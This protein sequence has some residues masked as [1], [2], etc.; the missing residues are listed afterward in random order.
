M[1][2]IGKDSG[3]TQ[4]TEDA[5]ICIFFAHGECHR[6]EKCYYKH[7]IPTEGDELRL[8]LL[9]DVFGRDRHKTDREDMG[10]IGSFSRNNRTLY[11]GG[12]SIKERTQN[13]LEGVL[14]R[15]F[16]P[17]GEIE[18]IRVI[19][20][21]SIGFVRYKLRAAAEF[22]KEAMHDVKIGEEVVN[23]RW[24]HEDPNKVAQAYE[25]RALHSLAQTVL[26]RHIEEMTEE[27]RKHFEQMQMVANQ[28]YPDTNQQYSSLT[29]SSSTHSSAPK[30]SNTLQLAPQPNPS[31]SI[32]PSIWSKMSEEQK[33]QYYCQY[34]A[35][36][37]A[38]YYA[39]LMQQQ[40]QGGNPNANTAAPLPIQQGEKGENNQQ[41]QTEKEGENNQL[42][43]KEGQVVEGVEVKGGE[44]GGEGEKEEEGEKGEKG[45]EGEKKKL[46]V[47]NKYTKT[48]F[49]FEDVP[50]PY[51]DEPHPYSYKD[52][53]WNRP[54]KRKEIKKSEDKNEGRE[55]GEGEGEGEQIPV[56]QKKRHVFDPNDQYGPGMAHK[57]NYMNADFALTND[58]PLEFC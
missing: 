18:Y 58:Q 38:T 46:F 47:F 50:N 3:W 26:K 2:D 21:K 54:K 12:L 17:F 15:Y 22:A 28:Q 48:E 53:G 7:Q 44:K 30:S 57:S 41:Q 35:Q 49:E 39:S 11:I 52:Y 51:S 10:G 33:K 27:E 42:E 32:D 1:V 25:K 6:G 56:S 13:Q 8:S 34:Y 31:S 14:R 40:K 23:V 29:D 5:F 43:K 36:Y 16:S 45:E 19:M 20:S 24:A 9:K 55:K 37:Y 4:A